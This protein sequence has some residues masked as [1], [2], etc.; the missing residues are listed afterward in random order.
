MTKAS[1]HHSGLQVGNSCS[2]ALLPGSN[3]PIPYKVIERI[4]NNL[5]K[6]P[7]TF[8]GKRI[9]ISIGMAT[10]E[11]GVSLIEFCKA[12]DQSMDA[13]KQVKRDVMAAGRHINEA[14]NQ[15]RSHE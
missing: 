8:L 3:A 2:A 13:G 1:D 15:W 4:M 11:N 5:A 9:S 7:C 12:A 14:E 10:T 6:A